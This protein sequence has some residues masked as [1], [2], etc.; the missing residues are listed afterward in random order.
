[1]DI[2]ENK[3]GLRYNVEEDILKYY[4]IPQFIHVGRIE[5]KEHWDCWEHEHESYEWIYIEKGTMKYWCNDVCMQ[6]S[7]G[8][9]YYIQ[10]GQTHKEDSLTSGVD[11]YYIKFGYFDLRGRPFFLMPFPGDPEN[12]IV[13]RIDNDFR[14]MIKSV[15]REGI[16]KQPGAKQIIEAKL[17]EMI[18]IIR[19]KLNTC[20]ETKE[21]PDR[22]TELTRTAIKYIKTNYSKKILLE[23]ICEHCEISTG[24]L[25]HVFKKITD[26]SPLQYRDRIRMEEAKKLIREGDLKLN[27]ISEKVGMFDEFYFSKRFKKLVGVSPKDYKNNA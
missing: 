12:Q 1:M 20:E 6:A 8:D 26:F 5:T 10:P 14:E 15:Y 7:E 22:R 25:S 24:Y 9:F 16:G 4:A 13:R 23:D 17:L 21:Q 27:E 2:Y 3:I 11:F 19:R 18:W